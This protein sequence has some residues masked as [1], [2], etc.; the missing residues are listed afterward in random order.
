MN[1]VRGPEYMP[2]AFFVN[3]FPECG[4]GLT[5]DGTNRRAEEAAIMH[6]SQTFRK[7]APL[8]LVTLMTLFCIFSI[9]TA[10]A[11]ESILGGADLF[12]SMPFEDLYDGDVRM[13]GSEQAGL[14]LSAGSAPN[15]SHYVSQHS[16]G[17]SSEVGVR[18]SWKLSW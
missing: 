3:W 10:K 1:E 15:A 6:A 14:H 5:D 13:A 8:V 7:S 16:D 11:E 9:S 2:Q 18:M 4:A 12:K 17:S